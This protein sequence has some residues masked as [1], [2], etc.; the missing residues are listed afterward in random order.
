MRTAESTPPIQRSSISTQRT[1]RRRIIRSSHRAISIADRRTQ[2]PSVGM[3]T[4]ASRGLPTR[5]G[6]TISPCR[7]APT[8]MP[9]A[10]IRTLFRPCRDRLRRRTRQRRRTATTTRS[11]LPAQL[12]PARSTAATRTRRRARR[13]RTRSKSRV[14]RSTILSAVV[15]SAMQRRIPSTSPRM[16]RAVLRAAYPRAV[17]LRRTS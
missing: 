10:A 7:A 8:R 12:S 4:A 14:V 5:R 13:P 3:S 1:A 9:T 16:S 6:R 15:P 2:S 17:R 11:R